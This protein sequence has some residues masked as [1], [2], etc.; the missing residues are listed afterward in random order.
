MLDIPVYKRPAGAETGIHLRSRLIWV[1]KAHRLDWRE[2]RQFTVEDVAPWDAPSVYHVFIA[3]PYPDDVL[4]DG[5]LD[6]L[7]EEM[8]AWGREQGYGRNEVERFAA[9][10][11]W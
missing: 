11:T 7:Q 3:P 10:C 1:V 9:C 8:V 5:L 6:D 4:P 2:L